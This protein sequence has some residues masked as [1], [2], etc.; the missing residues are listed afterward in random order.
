MDGSLHLPLTAGRARSRGARPTR[1][2]V[3]L[4]QHRGNHAFG[5]ILLGFLLG[6]A[7]TIAVM[8][9]MDPRPA[10]PPGPVTATEPAKVASP[11]Y[12]P[13]QLQALHTAASPATAVAGSPPAIIAL[14]GG[15]PPRAV[16]TPPAPGVLTAEDAAATGMTA[17]R[18]ST[19]V[20]VDQL[21]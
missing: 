4:K 10:P 18:R 21:F 13:I 14:P 1:R 2:L 5:L 3:A 20:Q 8:M 7:A 19:S 16:K 11:V 6:V 17:R 12:A 15:P 9:Q